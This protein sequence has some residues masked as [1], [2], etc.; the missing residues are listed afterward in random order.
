VNKFNSYGTLIN[1]LAINKLLSF[2]LYMD[3]FGGPQ[4]NSE[5]SIVYQDTIQQS[6]GWDC[7]PHTVANCLRCVYAWDRVQHFPHPNMMDFRL[8]V[9]VLAASQVTD[10]YWQGRC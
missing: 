4:F 1:N 5:C 3:S 8:R 2:L 10:G 9:A 6:N 7:G